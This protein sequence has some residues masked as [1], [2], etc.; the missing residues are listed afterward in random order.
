MMEK[1]LLDWLQKPDVF[2]VNKLAAHSDH[3]Y[4]V[5]RADYKD[6]N[7]QIKTGMAQL[8]EKINKTGKMKMQLASIKK[9]VAWYFQKMIIKSIL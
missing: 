7:N 3:K 9:W 8:K 4:Y 1:P 6:E 5:S 2:S